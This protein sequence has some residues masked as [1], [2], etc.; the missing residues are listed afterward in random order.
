[1]GLSTQT[2][3]RRTSLLF[4]RYHRASSQRP[5]SACERSFSWPG[6]I[7]GNGNRSILFVLSP[8]IARTGLRGCVQSEIPGED[9]V[10]TRSSLCRWM[11]NILSALEVKH[12][13][14]ERR[15]P[16]RLLS[17][18][19]RFRLIKHYLVEFNQLAMSAANGSACHDM[20]NRVMTKDNIGIVAFLETKEEIYSHT[21]SNGNWSQRHPRLTFFSCTLGV[22]PPDHNQMLFVCTAHIHWDPEYCDVKIVQTLMLLSEVKTIMEDAIETYRSNTNRP[23]D[24]AAV[25]LVLCGDFNSLPD[26]GIHCSWS[27]KGRTVFS[28]QV[29]SNWFV[30]GQSLSIMLTSK[31]SATNRIF[32][33]IVESIRILHR[34]IQLYIISN[35]NQ[36]MK[37]H[38]HRSC[39]IRTLRE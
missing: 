2:D 14:T 19:N 33:S 29:W 6:W 32:R 12:S 7:L 34:T 21:F 28:S 24:C 4:R 36:P 17:R 37:T 39:P 10:W 8:W 5:R 13:L 25:P 9:Y 26:S 18:K 3:S 35:S 16:F 1:M 38:L 11:C 20:M 30:M 15:K 23:L 31:I 22:V 27:K